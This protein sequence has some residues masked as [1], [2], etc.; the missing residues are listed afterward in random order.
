MAT[1]IIL[2][3]DIHG[4]LPAF[5]AVIA[6]LP[7][8]DAVIVAGDHCLDG[9]NPAEVLDLLHELR[10]T[11]IMGNTDHDILEPPQDLK[12]HKL[13][14]L[15]WTRE[16]LGPERLRRLSCLDFSARIRHEEAAIPVLG[17]AVNPEDPLVHRSAEQN[18]ADLRNDIE[19]GEDALLVVHAN[20]L[21]L[22][23]QLYPTM[24]EEQLRPYL[25]Y[26]Q[27]RVL[28]FGHLHIPYIRPV[29]DALLLDV[30]SVG[31]PKDHDRRAAYTVL[32]WDNGSRSLT[33]VRVPYDVEETVF[34]M[35]RSGMPDVEKHIASLLK[36]SY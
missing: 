30:A 2:L 8:H 29:G 22:D 26:M 18:W 3:S 25:Q 36:A 35:R 24:S 13:R 11:L 9:P 12:G 27:A 23:E 15:E 19:H 14:L 21:N 10:W 16:Q 33:Q 7:E 20:P 28:A 31:H 17:P 34:L 4:N 6:S 32:R 5:R 1:R